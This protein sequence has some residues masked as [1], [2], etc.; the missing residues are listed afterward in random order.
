MQ[1]L[2][3]IFA[4]TFIS[5]SFIIYW[6]NAKYNLLKDKSSIIQKPYSYSRVQLTWWTLIIISSFISIFISKGNLPI[7]DNSLIILLGISSATTATAGIIDVA[8][9]SKQNVTLIQNM[10]SE[11]FFLDILSDANGV[12][13]HRLQAVLFNLVI[14]I[15]V[16]YSVLIGMKTCTPS[17]AANCINTIIPVIDANKL[18]LLGVSATTYAAIKTNEN[19]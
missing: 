2:S 1:F 15:W 13:I 12:S 5:L 11:G 9:Q 14:G 6:L 18:L 4:I 17:V 3:L 10:Q 16:I 19:K 7:L 8:D